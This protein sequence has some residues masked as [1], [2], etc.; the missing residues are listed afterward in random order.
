MLPET[1]RIEL[2]AIFL[3]TACTADPQASAPTTDSDTSS[4]TAAD[5]TGPPPATAS[6]TDRPTP[7]EPTTGSSDTELTSPAEPTT[8][9]TEFSSTMPLTSTTEPDGS[10]CGDGIIGPF[11]QCDEG[12][13]NDNSGAC[14]LA[15]KDAACGDGLVYAGVEQC[16]LGRGNGDSYGGCLDCVLGPHCGD[17]ILDEGYE[18]CDRGELNG[19]GKTEDEFAPCSKTC[20]YY[21]RIMFV[22]E[23]LYN[24]ALGGIS[25]AD[26]KCRKSAL[27]AGLAHP[28]T[29]RAWI[30]DSFQ[31]PETRFDQWDLPGIRI[32][33]PGGLVIADDL[34]DLVFN[35]PRIGISETE[36][37]E[38]VVEQSVW[39]NTSDQGEI[40]IPADHCD[41]WLSA[42]D[43]WQARCGF[44]AL[45]SA[46]DPLWDAWL[47]GRWW[48]NDVTVKCDQFARLYCI[49]DGFVLDE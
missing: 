24:G 42:K 12:S 48:T 8:T 2:V 18:R 34:G 9:T 17:G 7:T 27:D 11:E 40:F 5:P 26:L 6:T 47:T 39:T 25:G 37:G 16:D 10:L 33:L 44:N 1:R 32:M 3:V 23:A 35:G 38:I 46:E 43:T 49:D 28:N 21:G 22:T 29:Y 20:G 19:T 14:T 36:S 45:A 13:D 31:S 4:S 30:S 15:C 41:N